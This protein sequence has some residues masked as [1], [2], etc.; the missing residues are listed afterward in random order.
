MEYELQ[1][2]SM[3]IK[4]TV[5]IQFYSIQECGYYEQETRKFAFCNIEKMLEGLYS[6]T[7][8]KKI[9][10]TETFH[11]LE[12]SDQDR[13]FCYDIH[14]AANEDSVITTWN[15]AQSDDE[16]Q[17][18]AVN[19]DATL[20]TDDLELS[21]FSAGYMPGYETYFWFPKGTRGR[22]NIF[23]TIRFGGR[24]KNGRDGL[25]AY[26]QAFLEYHH[27]QYVFEVQESEESDRYF[28]YGKDNDTAD[29]YTPL[30]SNQIRRLPGKIE[31]IRANRDKIV[32]IARKAEIRPM[33]KEGDR[34]LW[35]KILNFALLSEPTIK[36]QLVRLDTKF[37]F[38]PSKS[39]LEEMIKSWEIE[40]RTASSVMADIGVIYRGDSNT[41]HW[42]SS[43]LAKGELD[44][45]VNKNKQGIVQAE[46]LAQA[47]AEKRNE[48]FAK[49]YG[50]DFDN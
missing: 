10:L 2:E 3:R 34:A 26:I 22:K 46:S 16:G 11:P 20:G 15:A 50:K 37:R 21:E 41:T 32:K 9:A 18:A 40:R 43:C 49:A 13:I 47:L 45:V 38:S 30:F 36:E 48:I 35:Q 19:I 28:V 14:Y 1:E 23:A 12:D 24:V 31:E 33:T 44:I 17:I 27:P 42:F 4:E 25:S 6:W 5:K 29:V 8:G 7:R 39:Q